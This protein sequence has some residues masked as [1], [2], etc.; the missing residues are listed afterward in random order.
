MTLIVGPG[1]VQG[2]VQA[3]P[4]KSVTHRALFAAFLAGRGTIRAP[5]IGA[6]TLAS[7]EAIEAFGATVERRPDELVVE[8]STVEPA[9]IDVDN[10]G[11]TLRIATAVAALAAGTSRLTGDASIRSRPMGPLVD[12]LNEI[13]ASARCEGTD[14]T[15]PV[16]V[17]GP[18]NGGAVTVDASVSSQFITALCLIGPH[19]TQGID[20]TFK[21]PPVSR[22]YIDLT[23]ETLERGGVVVETA[24][25]RISIEHQ[26][27]EPV[28]M[29]IPGDY[30]GAAFPLV[31]G[32]MTG[33]P[34]TVEG[35][36][37]DSIQGDAKIVEF[38]RAFGTEL[39][40]GDSWVTV[41][42]QA[43]EPTRLDLSM[44]P[45]LFPP[46]AALAAC[47]DGTSELVGA[48]HLR[49]KE[50]DRI[51]SMVSGLTT[52][53]IEA[54]ERDDGATIHGGSPTGGVV[55]SHDDHR[56]QMALALLGLRASAPVEVTGRDDV[57]RVSYPGF[58]EM[59]ETLGATPTLRTDTEEVGT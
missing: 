28:S 40:V 11:T 25:D 12:A 53:G 41:S 36:D 23:I 45:D 27:T 9:T 35:L 32:A 59:L 29:T 48:P 14:G 24:A 4:S 2:T 50:S 15:P 21:N 7:I 56:I 54:D 6:D 1:G 8:A 39:E 13:G 17:I 3:P 38:L 20:I 22:P 34:V 31:A 57:H 16:E 5:L 51:A 26:P 30:S 46:L 10:S 44:T 47:V 52:L 49:D 33:G 43:L 18:A 42:G 19:L 55:D 37:P 58:I